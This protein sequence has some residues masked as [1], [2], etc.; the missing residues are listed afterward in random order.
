MLHIL[1]STRYNAANA[2]AETLEGFYAVA[3]AQIN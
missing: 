1:A 3:P 2:G